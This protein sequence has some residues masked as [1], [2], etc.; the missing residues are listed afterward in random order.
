MTFEFA[1]GRT[2]AAA[3]HSAGLR[4]V[5]TSILGGFQHEYRLEKVAA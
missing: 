1:E 2:S 3:L 5:A 4:I